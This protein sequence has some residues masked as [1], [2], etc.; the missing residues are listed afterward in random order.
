ME[1]NVDYDHENDILIAGCQGSLKT[2]HFRDYSDEILRKLQE[3]NCI[4][5]L[6]DFRNVRIEMT[7]GEIFEWHTTLIKDGLNRKLKRAIVTTEQYL[8]DVRFYENVGENMG[9]RVKAFTE[10]DDAINWLKE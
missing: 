8:E 10:F 5:L 1:C 4:Q 2:E 3:H 7:I 6:N 9:Y